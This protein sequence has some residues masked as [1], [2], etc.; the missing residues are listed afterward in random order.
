MFK[1]IVQLLDIYLIVLSQK[2]E[3]ETANLLKEVQVVCY[4]GIAESRPRNPEF[5]VLS[6]VTFAGG[7]I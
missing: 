7:W 6:L 1:G 2:V 3:Q 4:Q 5:Q